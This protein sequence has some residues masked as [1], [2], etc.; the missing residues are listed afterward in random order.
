MLLLLKPFR[1][2]PFMHLLGGSF[3][4]KAR[5]EVSPPSRGSGT[6]HGEINPL[7]LLRTP[8]A[9]RGGEISAGSPGGMVN[10]RL[11]NSPPTAG[12]RDLLP[13]L[14]RAC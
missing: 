5:Q 1:W 14:S 2:P 12:A 11:V 7:A 4:A 6:G 3:G 8:D 9:R 13:D 10:G